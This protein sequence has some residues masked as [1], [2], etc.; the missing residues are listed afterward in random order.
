ML[1][2]KRGKLQT[3]E[4][5]LIKKNKTISHIVTECLVFSSDIVWEFKVR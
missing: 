3:D 1:V 2:V 5:M 4:F